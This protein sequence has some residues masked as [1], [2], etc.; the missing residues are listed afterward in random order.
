MLQ[1]DRNTPRWGRALPTPQSTRQRGLVVD[2]L[3][4]TAT[5][6]GR[7]LVGLTA[8][9][10]RLLAHLVSKH[11][12][13]IPHATLATLGWPQQLAPGS[14][15]VYVAMSRL[16]AK[17]PPNTISTVKQGYRIKK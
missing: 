11:G 9:E 14:R 17:L 10:L 4:S 12:Q 15:A 13:P 8:R 3:G 16:R 5:Y 1:A 6:A 2:L 7:P